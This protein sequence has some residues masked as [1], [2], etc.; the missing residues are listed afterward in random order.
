[1]SLISIFFMEAT[2]DN[3]RSSPF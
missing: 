3:S 1:M 2:E